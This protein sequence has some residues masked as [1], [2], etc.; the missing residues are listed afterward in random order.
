[1]TAQPNTWM[2]GTV[3]AGIGAMQTMDALFS[4]ENKPF[5]PDFKFKPYSAA[6]DMLDGS[7]LGEGWAMAVMTFTAAL[8]DTQRYKIAQFVP[9]G[10]SNSILLRCPTNN[11]DS[12]G[13]HIWHTF[14]C[15]MIWPADYETRTIWQGDDVGVLG[16]YTGEPGYLEK[17]IFTFRAFQQLD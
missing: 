9:S 1:M 5:E 8:T 10:L 14:Q 16:V 12:N 2:M 11:T 4:E 7:S 13:I 17:P 6:A 3:A 15:E